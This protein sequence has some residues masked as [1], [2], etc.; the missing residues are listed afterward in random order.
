MEQQ[1]RVTIMADPAGAGAPGLSRTPPT[2][3]L[4]MQERRQQ[5]CS[6]I[7]LCQSGASPASMSGSS[8]ASHR[9]TAENG[10]LTSVQSSGWV[11]SYKLTPG[12]TI[13]VST[14]NVSYG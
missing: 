5:D 9:K 13:T 2:R 10:S 1:P 6:P 4:S 14:R 12:R 3:F 11:S 8:S 7:P